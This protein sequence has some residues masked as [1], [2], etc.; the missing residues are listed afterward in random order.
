MTI[1]RA[2]VKRIET[3]SKLRIPKSAAVF[4]LFAVA[5]ALAAIG[6]DPAFA[7][8]SEQAFVLLLPTDLYIASGVSVVAL[9]VVAVAVL[10]HEAAR[11][12]FSSATLANLPRANMQ[13]A[14]SLVSFAILA[15]LLYLGLTGTANPTENLLPLMIW[16]M[17]WMGFV[18]VQALLG[19]IWRLINPWSGVYSVLSPLWR[20]RAFLRLPRWLGSWP[21]VTVFVF[22]GCFMLADVS[23]EDPTRLAAIV[24]SYWAFTFFCMVLFGADEWLERGECFTMVL[25]R[26]ASLAFLGHLGGQLRIGIPGWRLMRAKPASSKRG[27]SR[28]ADTRHRQF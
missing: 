15:A 25:R 3:E 27:C 4:R 2:F 22:F 12:I 9:T 26:Y 21:G 20:R 16:T 18:I 23:P 6:L 28:I 14:S 13:T 7:H 19:D 11:S 17:W 10:P 24:A 8:T 1:W 5:I